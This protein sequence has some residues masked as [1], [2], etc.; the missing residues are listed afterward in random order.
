LGSSDRSVEPH[1][2]P[3]AILPS[4]VMGCLVQQH[5]AIRQQLGRE[6]RK[7]LRSHRIHRM[8]LPMIFSAAPIK[9][10]N[11]FSANAEAGA[12]CIIL[13]S[14]RACP[15]SGWGRFFA[16]GRACCS[17]GFRGRKA[18][19][20]ALWGRLLVDPIARS[21]RPPHYRRRGVSA[22]AQRRQTGKQRSPGRMLLGSWSRIVRPWNLQAFDCL[23]KVFA[24]RR[25]E[26][27][28]SWYRRELDVARIDCGRYWIAN[29]SDR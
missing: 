16:R 14:A 6:I 29:Q 25:S 11:S 23:S 18:G 12:K 3:N 8:N 10:P 21:R 13:P 9:L 7:R 1:I 24:C 4:A 17:N 27:Y 15:S 22:G 19:C 20:R 28:A 5:Q 2:G 26:L